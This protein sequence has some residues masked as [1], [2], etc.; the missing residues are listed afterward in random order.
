MAASGVTVVGKGVA[1]CGA[2]WAI[3]DFVT[4]TVTGGVAD[5]VSVT[6]VQTN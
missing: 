1:E 2:N 6:F 3:P 5:I 4:F